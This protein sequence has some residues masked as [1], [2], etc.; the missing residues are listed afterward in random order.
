MIKAAGPILH[1]YVDDTNIS[2]FLTF[3]SHTSDI[4]SHV[5]ELLLSTTP[6]SMKI[7][8]SK[9]KEMLL[10]PLLKLSVPGLDI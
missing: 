9:T 1:K 5:N 7:E 8:Y 10:G 4:H 2:E 3:T 6:N